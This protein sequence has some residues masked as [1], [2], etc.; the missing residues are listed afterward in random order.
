MTDY[1][2]KSSI[3]IEFCP[4]DLMVIIDFTKPTQ[5]ERL[6]YSKAM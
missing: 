6:E 3:S 4:I 2:E 5:I 1:G